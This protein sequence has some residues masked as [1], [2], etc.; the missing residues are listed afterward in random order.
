MARVED[1]SEFG[2]RMG[3]I[4]ADLGNEQS[5]ELTGKS[6]RQ[7]KRYFGGDEPPFSVLK[8]LVEASG[9]TLDWVTFGRPN[10]IKDYELSIRANEIKIVEI[11]RKLNKVTAVKDAENLKAIIALNRK[12]NRHSEEIIRLEK[13]IHEDFKVRTG[14]IEGIREERLVLIAGEA[15]VSTYRD[16]KVHL[17]ANA[18]PAAIAQF[19]SS[20]SAMSGDAV[21]ERSVRE[22]LP[23]LIDE[24]RTEI[25]GATAAP[26]T[27][28]REAS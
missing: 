4:V 18:L 8:N 17:P 28:K 24:L 26:G 19:Y 13:K 1:G 2:L 9:A 7:L 10:S 5:V 6:L 12:I 21:D 23:E 16:E 27:G 14:R 15:V 20:L 11:Q 3:L 25:R 22:H